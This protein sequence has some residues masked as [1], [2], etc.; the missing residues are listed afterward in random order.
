[1]AWL[2]RLPGTKVIAPGNHDRW[3]NGVD[4]IRAMLRRSILAVEG[5]AIL[6]KDVVVCGT[7][8]S[9]AKPEEDQD[10]DPQVSALAAAL[11]Q[12]ESLAK[13]VGRCMFFGITRRSIASAARER[14]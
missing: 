12:A 13:E 8:G 3:W 7:R 6:V 1:M 11:E 10:D 9:V 2:D 14:P 5:D 4:K